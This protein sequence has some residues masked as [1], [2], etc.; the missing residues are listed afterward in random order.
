MNLK[1]E[2]S[3]DIVDSCSFCFLRP[4]SDEAGQKVN[5]SQSDLPH[6]EKAWSSNAFRFSVQSIALPIIIG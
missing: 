2:W 6:D 1:T 4:I 5:H 3:T